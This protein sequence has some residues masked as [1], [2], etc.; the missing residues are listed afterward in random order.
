MVA[1]IS[2]VIVHHH[3]ESWH[4]LFLVGRTQ[5]YSL[6]CFQ[7]GSTA[8]LTLV[9]VLATTAPGRPSFTTGMLVLLTPATS[10]SS[11]SVYWWWWFVLC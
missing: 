3:T 8:L 7:T 9:T 2:P 6:S 11:V 5:V 10:L 4:L 1:T